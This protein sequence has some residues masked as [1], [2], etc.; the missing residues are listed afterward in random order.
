MKTQLQE[1]YVNKV[2]LNFFYN[3]VRRA[4]AAAEKTLKIFYR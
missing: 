2:I 1:C 4:S 3:S